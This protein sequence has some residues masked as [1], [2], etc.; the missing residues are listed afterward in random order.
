MGGQPMIE[1]RDQLPLAALS[2]SQTLFEVGLI[3]VLAARRS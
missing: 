1:R 2:D 3:I